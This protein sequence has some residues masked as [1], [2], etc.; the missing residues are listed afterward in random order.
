MSCGVGHRCTSDSTPSL[1]TSICC[2]CSCKKKNKSD[3]KYRHFEE[4]HLPFWKQVFTCLIIVPTE[5][6]PCHKSY[7]SERAVERDAT[8]EGTALYSKSQEGGWLPWLLPISSLVISHPPSPWVSE[9]STCRKSTLTRSQ[10]SP[11]SLWGSIYFLLY[12]EPPLA[13]TFTSEEIRVIC[14]VNSFASYA[15]LPIFKIKTCVRLSRYLI[16]LIC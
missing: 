11:F 7:G 6:L 15:A 16:H 4:S 13:S 12:H 2:R 5:Y 10:I 1:G 3:M 8:P 9:G 14:A